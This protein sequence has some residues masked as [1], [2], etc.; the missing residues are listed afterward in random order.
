MTE[1]TAATGPA[2]ADALARFRAAIVA[3][4]GRVVEVPDLAAVAAYAAERARTRRP[5][6]RVVVERGARDEAAWRA[7]ADVAQTILSTPPEAAEAA[8]ARQAI[9]D[10]DVCVGLVD[11]AIAETGQ[12]VLYRSGEWGRLL[13]YLAPIYVGVVRADRFVPTLADFLDGLGAATV[14]AT[15]AI[16]FVSGCSV[17]ADIENIITPGVHGPLELH[18]LVLPS[19]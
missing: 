6:P 13:A 7:H 3:Y 11:W 17:S 15:P 12:A 8:A 10:S 4:G 5:A 19:T 16:T 2:A 14:A 9:I 18:L 1:P